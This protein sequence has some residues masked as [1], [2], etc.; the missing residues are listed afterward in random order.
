MNF[1]I[2]AKL[3]EIAHR[4]ISKETT[5]PYLRGVFVEPCASGGVSIVATDGHRM[6]VCYDPEGHI[7]DPAILTADKSVLSACKKASRVSKQED[8]RLSDLFSDGSHVGAHVI[9][10]IDGQF[11]DWQRVVP[12]VEGDATGYY[13]AVYLA[14]FCKASKDLYKVPGSEFSKGILKVTA[15]A[16]DMPALV[17][18]GHDNAFGV[19]MPLRGAAASSPLSIME[20]INAAPGSPKELA[21]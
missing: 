1:N 12:Q 7:S 21:A 3:F 13:Q 10:E 8:S 11:P 14:D 16:D 2:D 19:L 15:Q 9:S 4:F 6:F 20:K 17:H 5:R 18:L